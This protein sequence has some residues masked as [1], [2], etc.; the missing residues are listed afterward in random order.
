MFFETGREILLPHGL[1]DSDGE[2][3]RAAVLRPLSGRDEGMLGAAA[4]GAPGL[5][6]R[7]LAAC[8]A[9]IGGYEQPGL[10]HVA[11]LTR[12]DRLR[13]ALWIRGDLFGDR[14]PLVVT[15]PNPACRERADMD[16]QISTLASV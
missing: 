13:L 16:L 9:R 11:A 4:P 12:G 10:E 3:H 5:L 8:L 7:L 6:S 15:C 2:R 14:L 1:V